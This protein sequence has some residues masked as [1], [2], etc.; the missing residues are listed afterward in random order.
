MKKKKKLRL[1]TKIILI[2][3]SLILAVAAG[4]GAFLIIGASQGQAE[5]EESEAQY[6][7]TLIEAPTDGSLPTDHNP[8][9]V[10]AY[11]LWTV[12]NTSEF[13]VTTTGTANA[14][15]ATQQ[16]SNSR[17]VKDGKAMISTVSSG[18][19]NVAKQRYFSDGKVLLRDP[20]K[21]DGINVLWKD[22]IPECITYNQN[23]KRYGWLPF[24]ANGYIIC[25]ET[26]LNKDEIELIDNNDGTYLIKFDLDPADDKAPFWYR[27]EVLTNAS[28]QM[29]PRF[30]S[31][32]MEFTIDAK[33]RILKQDIQ[34]KYTVKSMGIEAGTTTDCHD[35]F[36]YD[37][38]EFD[39]DFLNYFLKYGNLTPSEETDDDINT[40]IDNLTM[41]VES[42]M[43]NTNPLD[44]VLDINGTK[45]N[46]K[47]SLDISD[48]TNVS[49]KALIDQLYVEFKDN[50]LFIK[51]GD[52]LKLKSSIDD[53]MGLLPESLDTGMS[54]D[55]SEIIAAINNA[56]VTEDGNIIRFSPTL[57]LAGIELPLE[58]EIEKTDDSYKLLNAKTNIKI[59]NINLNAEIKESTP[60][61][62]EACDYDTFDEIKNIKFITDNV[63]DI[64]AKSALTI[65]GDVSYKDL[66]LNIDGYLDFKDNINLDLDLNL[67]YKDL[68]LP[69]NVKFINDTVYFTYDDIKLELSTI[70]LAIMLVKYANIDITKTTSSIDISKIIDIILSIDYSKLIEE[71]K[72]DTDLVSVKLGLSE[73]IANLDSLKLEIKNNEGIDLSVLYQELAGNLNVKAADIKTITKPENYNK[74]INLSYLIDDVLV[75]TKNKQAHLS[76]G[77]KYDEL[78]INLDTYLDFNSDIELFASLTLEYKTNSFNIN[79]HFVDNAIYLEYD[80]LMVYITVDDLM[81]LLGNTSSIDTSNILDIITS[82]DFAKIIENLVLNV[83]ETVISLNLSDYND[84][85]Q[86]FIDLSNLV[87]IKIN[88]TVSG[89]KVSANLLDLNIDVDTTE[90]DSSVFEFDNSK[91]YNLKALIENILDLVNA[92]LYQI[93]VEGEYKDIKLSLVGYFNRED[94]SLEANIN[95]QYKENKFDINVYL[96]DNVIYLSLMDMKV[97]ISIDDIKSLFITDSS[98][99]DI[100]ELLN[101]ILSKDLNKILSKINF[102]NEEMNIRLDIEEFN[103][104]LPS[105]LEISNVIDINLIEVEQ[106]LKLSIPELFNLNLGLKKLTNHEITLDTVDFYDIKPVI[107]N[108]M[109]L[110]DN[111]KYEIKLSGSYKD[112]KL[113]GVAKLDRT[114]SIKAM[115]NLNLAYK[116]NSFDIDVYF[117]D[118]VIYLSYDEAYLSI[119]IDDIMALIPSADSEF[120]ID[121][122][123]NTLLSLD[124]NKVLNTLKLNKNEKLIVLDLSDLDIDLMGLI[125][126]Q[127]LIN[128]NLSEI[129]DGV[130][131]SIPEVFN[132]EVELEVSDFE[133]TLDTDKYYDLAGVVNNIKNI[134]DNTKYEIK[135]RGSYKDINLSGIAKLDRTDSIKAEVNLNITYKTNSFDINAYFI[136]N[137]IYL[138]FDEMFVKVSLDDIMSLIPN[139]DSEISIDSLLDTL[140][141]LDLN[142]VLNTVKLNKNEKLITLDLSDIDVDLK[143]L[144]D[145]QQL[146]NINL[147]EIEDGIKLSIPELF[148]LEVE[149]NVS[150]F[151]ITLDDSNYYDVKPVIDNIMNLID[152]TKYEIK[153]SGSY[154]DIN[155]SGI[156][157]LDRTDSIK[158]EV[159]LNITYKT[160]SFDINVYFIDNVIY[161]AYDEAYLSISLE[162][163]MALIPDA[164]SEFSVD[165]LLDTLLSL[166]LNKVLNTI[167]LNKNEKL[168]TLDL[169]DL[170]I[171][172]KGIIDLQQ[173]ININLAEIEDGVKLSI[174]EIFNLE[175][176]L[177]VSDFDIT[178]SD[179]DKYYNLSGVVNNIKNIIDNTKYEIKL[180]GA[181]KD[182]NLNVVAHLD[183]TEG[184]KAEANINLAYKTN[185]FD[186]KVFYIDD[187]I[188]LSYDEMFVKVSLE[189]IMTLIPNTDSEFSIDSLLDTLLSLDLNKVLNTV[190]L[191]KNEKL[192]TL[193]LSDVEVDLMGLI[194]LQQLI[195]INLAEIED[196]IKLSIPELF[197][198][199]AELNVSDFEIELT[200]G[201]KYYDVKPLIDNIMTLIDNTKYE[202]KLRGSYKDINLSGVAHLDRTE[203]IKAEVALNITYKTNSFDINVYFIDNVIYLS[204]DEAYLSISI[205]DIMALIPDA[206]SEFSVDSLLDTLLS[207]DLNK[208]LNTIKLNKN[209]KLITLDLS[210]LEIDLKGIID[211]QQ[212]ININLS[213][214]EDGVKLSIPEIFNL[215]VELEVSDFEITLSDEDRYY[216]LSNVVNNIKNIIDSTKYEIKLSG[217][218]KDVTLRSTGLLDRELLNVNLD[219]NLAYKTY[220]YEINIKYFN[221]TKEIFISMNNVKLFLNLESIL[222]RFG[223]DSLSVDEILNTLLSLDLNKVLNSVKLNNLDKNITLD[224]SDLEVDLMGLIDLQQL[225]NINLSEIEDGIKLSIPELFNLDVEFNVKDF[226]EFE[227]PE[228]YID[229]SNI[230]DNVFYVLDMYKKESFRV[231]LDGE[232]KL[233]ELL[234]F[235]MSF[236]VNGYVDMLLEEDESYTIN[237]NMTISNS[238]LTV[239]VN[240][241]LINKVLYI[242]TCGLNIK[243]DLSDF[244]SFLTRI[245][246]I[247]EIEESPEEFNLDSIFGIID[248]LEFKNSNEL[249]VDLST[250]IS[251]LGVLTVN[252]ATLTEKLNANIS[253]S[254]ISFDVSVDKTNY[255]EVILKDTYLED[256]DIYNLCDIVKVILDLT[257][258]KNFNITLDL[259]V[260]DDGFRHLDVEG[261]VKFVIYENG[262]FDLELDGTIIEY[263]DNGSVKMTHMVDAILI[264]KEGFEARGIDK[265][266]DYLYLTYGTNPNNKSSKIKLYTKFDSVLSIVSTISNLLGLD[267]SFL[268]GYS[269]FSFNDI[270]TSQVTNLFG[271][272]SNQIDL[273][274][275][276]NSFSL[277]EKRLELLLNLNDIISQP[278]GSL[279]SFMLDVNKTD[280]KIAN[281]YVKNIYTVNDA[282]KRTMLDV[283]DVTLNN[284]EASIT[285]PTVNS[286][287]YDISGLDSLVDGLLVTASNKE[288]AINGTVRMKVL[289]LLNIDVPV[290]AKVHVDDEGN[291]SIYAHL[292]LS[293][294]GLGRLLVDAYHVYIYYENKYVYIYSKRSSDYYQIKISYEEFL[295]DIVYYLL[296]FGMGLSDTI[297]SQIEQSDSSS[298]SVD[299]GKVLNNYYSSNDDTKFYFSLDLGELLGNANLGDIE[300]QLGLREVVVSEDEEGIKKAYALTD[301]DSFNI[302]LVS[303]I[304]LT[305][306]NGLSLSNVVKSSDGNYRFTSV[307]LSA[308]RSYIDSYTYDVDMV[309]K[310]GKESGRRNHTVTFYTAGYGINNS[311][312]SGPSGSTFTYPEYEYITYEG[313]LYVLEGWYTNKGLTNKSDITT[314]QD[315]NIILYAKFVKGYILTLEVGNDTYTYYLAKGADITSKLSKL[316]TVKVDNKY[317][318]TTTYSLN[319]HIYTESVMPGENITLTANLQEIQYRLYIDN[320]FYMDFDP[321]TDLGLVSNYSVLYDG[322]YYNYGANNLTANVLLTRYMSNLVIDGMYGNFY[323]ETYD[324]GRS[325]YYTLTLDYSSSFA[326]NWYFGVTIPNDVTPSYEIFDFGSYSSY[327][328]NYWYNDLG[329]YYEENIS[330]ISHTNQTL[331]AYYY[332]N[333]YLGYGIKNNKA[334]ISSFDYS[335]SSITIILPKYVKIGSSY[336][337]LATMENISTSDEMESAFTG[338]TSIKAIYFNDGFET[339][340]GNAFKNCTSLT[341]VYLS[342][343]ITSVATDSFYMKDDETAAK[344]IRFYLTA[345][346]TLSHSDWLACKFGT[347]TSYNC[348]YGKSEKKNLW[349]TKLDLT[350]SFASY[351]NLYGLVHNL[352]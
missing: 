119:S 131:L 302:N 37:N 216:N 187:V 225:I 127:Q 108:I 10:I 262:R 107:D 260:Y 179:E 277:T 74:V 21:I 135:L 208:V 328:I 28:S 253:L 116:N 267:L 346:S 8:M 31:I 68:S 79:L 29:V 84:K 283:D 246:E 192:I 158:A 227:K 288:F 280:S 255:Y 14:L 241:S 114:D 17:I 159:S 303:V 55:T 105:F 182:I 177:N 86:G 275:I 313:E 134:I 330:E 157:K 276:I 193:D 273:N 113:T 78:N 202:I 336:Y 43:S 230:L 123:L 316:Y 194:D 58:F 223:A 141:S 271:S 96:I 173:L 145:L 143:G 338:K 100:K 144:I 188:Y 319:D 324:E 130:K 299:A 137:V 53:I 64:I 327:G 278:E 203:G 242:S 236:D 77:A 80:G 290:D 298:D 139:T 39:Q 151:E 176:E 348:H 81:S 189:D 314:I 132:L 109:N 256:D 198:L 172:L 295:S 325:E 140:L 160:N 170:E 146:I 38:I 133:I 320:E 252:I 204:Y 265:N 163:I 149:L 22:Q 13:K 67:S 286:S 161:L 106:G 148:N 154:K 15:V 52:N 238:M 98:D 197:N 341:K 62:F 30:E 245:Y 47:V 180:T 333:K 334:T 296:D 210:D 263:N 234:G 162:D 72:F 190:K 61:D 97:S 201:D 95:L 342:D 243:L 24:Q 153:L 293:D 104:N 122:L 120:S 103:L 82:I 63:F 309:Y 16:I 25:E 90:F 186:I 310:N 121:S 150:D 178:L 229:L 60:F 301:I 6:K 87:D 213:E 249:S 289:S 292:D 251:K 294:I 212:L 235:D 7:T 233:S 322:I 26:Y 46:G 42:L 350:S 270:D 261:N 35:V 272:V 34:E 27:R 101:I 200:D 349:G 239:D 2:I 221:D 306:K 85:L 323:I 191:N 33:Y 71:A 111:T 317:Y 112:I 339:I 257:K 51:L 183:R 343:T 274:H 164:D 329:E 199:E 185:S 218:Y 340:I 352:F 345:N 168:I 231:S 18:M 36:E 279:V 115:V 118:N 124:F 175:V 195:N 196:G 181:Y 44:L 142:K 211:L 23:I 326:S 254:G 331:Y 152:N 228:G 125:D 287:W 102:N 94:L 311:L 167:K 224:L 156:A 215:E 222:A 129:E 73:F 304:D 184:I 351:S 291:P 220:S 138:A 76:L 248:T 59:S 321:E 335:G 206:D 50:N 247:F 3:T 169:S 128:I 268:D 284:S 4:F 269:T 259:T 88:N 66:N 207:L 91:Y 209:E 93:D 312:V 282:T 5:I 165:S 264:S 332:T 56:E 307:D 32:H 171:D 147:S 226:D 344:N 308:L 205:D 300:A 9:D 57:N 347:L 315:S 250:I 83:D 244:E 217:A 70:D 214:I 40:E 237:A 20:E 89:F 136:D 11:S 48:L 305:L 297:L 99:I 65:K 69:V 41:L 166:D 318:I 337:I 49:V 12:A 258:E 92:K 155:L 240:L 266:E 219:I 285:V 45:V 232:V 1:R 174:P 117:I 54:I 19:V 110:I 75:I 126:L 281:L